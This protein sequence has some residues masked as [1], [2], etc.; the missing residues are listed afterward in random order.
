MESVISSDMN[1]L[2]N[3]IIPYLCNKLTIFILN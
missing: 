1:K 3:D 2:S